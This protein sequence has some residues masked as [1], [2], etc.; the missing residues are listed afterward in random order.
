[1][2]GITGYIGNG[3]TKKELLSSLKLLEYRGYDSS[4]IAI[5]NNNDITITKS[6]GKISNLEKLINNSTLANSNNNKNIKETNNLECGIA[7]TR[8]ATHG[9]PNYNNTHPFLSNDSNYSI[10]HN[11]IIENYSTLKDDLIKKGYTFSSETDTEVIV[12]Q[13][14]EELKILNNKPA[15]NNIESIINACKKLEGSFALAI[16]NKFANNT[17]FLAKRKSP[18]YVANFNNQTFVA[19]DP[20]CFV[21]KAKTYFSM[22]DNTFCIATENSLNFYD[23]N[24]NKITLTENKTENIDTNFNKQNYPHYMIK[25]ISETPYVLDRIIKTYT[26]NNP[27]KGI[28]KEFIKRFN[29]IVLIGCGTA[30]HASL[31]GASLIQKYCHIDCQAY[32]A[33]EYRYNNPLINKK[34]LCILVSQSGETADTLAVASLAKKHKAYTIALT[35]VLYSTLAKTVDF[36]LP[37]CAGPEI[38]VAST[39][40]YTAQITIL[41]MLAKHMQNTLKNKNYDYISDIDSI[42][43]TIMQDFS[44]DV[45]IIANKLKTQ[46]NVFFIG[47]DFDYITIKEAS[48]KL[49]EITYI[50]TAEHPAG[51]LK[52]GFLSLIDSKSIL[53]VLATEK[54]LLDKTLNGANEALSR[55]AKIVFVSQYNLPK[56]MTNK[57]YKFVKLNDTPQEVIPITSIIFFQLLAYQTSV[58]KNINPDQPRNLAKSVTVE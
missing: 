34:T 35:N 47:R 26:D 56:Q 24:H 39:K 6:E 23:I 13:I 28:N 11:G 43:A 40:A 52:H 37:V 7:H 3:N 33:S 21:G 46:R 42:K 57:F 51:E 17:I 29:K 15:N 49:K 22:P 50:N 36:V 53:F 41:Y 4:G 8:W 38:A 55:G 54:E 19:S 2:C 5:L 58:L 10:V 1:M 27:F 31:M 25:E 44:K 9:N 45:K 12:N 14:Q 48:L 16:L 32:I 20:I 30:Y 18:L